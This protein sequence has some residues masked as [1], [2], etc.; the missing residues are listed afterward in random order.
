MALLQLILIGGILLS[1]VL[2]SFHQL[3]TKNTYK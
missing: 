3:C 1:S 2:I